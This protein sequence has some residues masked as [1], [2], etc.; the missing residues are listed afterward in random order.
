MA[1]VSARNEAA[2]QQIAKI[3]NNTQEAIAKLVTRKRI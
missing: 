3:K 1:I 2:A